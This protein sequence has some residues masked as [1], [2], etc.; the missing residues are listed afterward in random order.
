M[1]PDRREFL[2]STL[3][4]GLLAATSGCRQSVRQ[5]G[6]S[7]SQLDEAAA[8]PVLQVTSI[9]TPVEIASIELLS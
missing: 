9:N 2:K 4:A 8:A 6:L 3:G 5:P 1:N 7:P